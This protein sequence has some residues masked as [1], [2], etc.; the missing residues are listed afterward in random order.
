VRRIIGAFDEHTSR[1]ISDKTTRVM[2]ESARQG[3]GNG[4]T[5]PLRLQDRRM[6]RHRDTDLC[7]LSSSCESRAGGDLP[8][9]GIVRAAVGLSQILKTICA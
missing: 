7:Q 9:N 4:A 3:F 1:E 6:Y 2:R 5:P 8:L